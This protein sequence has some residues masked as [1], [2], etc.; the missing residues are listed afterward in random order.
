MLLIDRAVVM[1]VRKTGTN[2]R[3]CLV[4]DTFKKCRDNRRIA[5]LYEKVK[6][7]V[8]GAFATGVKNLRPN[9]ERKA[10]HAG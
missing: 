3:Y 7:V 4:E 9:L 6:S 2:E 5:E 10:K 1:S 8:S